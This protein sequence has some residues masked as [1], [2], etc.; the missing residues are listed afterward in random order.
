[1]KKIRHIISKLSA[2]ILVVEY[3]IPNSRIYR[4]VKNCDIS[5]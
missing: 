5:K 4:F 3:P 2:N 1:M